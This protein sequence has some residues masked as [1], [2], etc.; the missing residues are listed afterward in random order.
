MTFQQE[1]VPLARGRIAYRLDSTLSGLSIQGHRLSAHFAAGRH[2]WADGWTVTHLPSGRSISFEP[3]LRKARVL[4]ARLEAKAEW[5][6]VHRWTRARRLRLLQRCIT[7][8]LLT[9]LQRVG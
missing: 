3:T 9:P 4:A 8:G 1:I 6:R 7:A 2:P 5:S